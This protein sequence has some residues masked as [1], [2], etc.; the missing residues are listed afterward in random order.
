M[1][2]FSTM[3]SSP[4]W[5]TE[6]LPRVVP[7]SGWHARLDEV[8]ANQLGFCPSEHAASL[9]VNQGDSPFQVKSEQNHF[10]RI[11]VSLGPV[12]LV[13]Q[14]GNGSRERE[15]LHHLIPHRPRKGD[16]VVAGH[17]L[18]GRTDDHDA[19]AESIRD[20]WHDLRG[21][22]VGAGQDVP[23]GLVGNVL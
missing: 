9:A 8:A 19:H 1:M 22:D 17:V 15:R 13:P 14:A 2:A 4:A 3:A 11:Q 21:G 7:Y 23:R 12:S 10:G 16:R 5:T 20:E 18:A 6:L